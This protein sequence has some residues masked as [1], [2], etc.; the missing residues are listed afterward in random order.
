MGSWPETDPQTPAGE[1]T[2]ELTRDPGRGQEPLD[3]PPPLPPGRHR[4]WV[5]RL[6]VCSIILLPIGLYYYRHHQGR[7]TGEAS[8]LGI[9]SGGVATTVAVARKGNIGVYLEAIGTVTPVYT[10]N[11]TSQVNGVVTAVHY[12]EGQMVKKGDLLVDIDPR[13]YEAFAFMSLRAA[14]SRLRQ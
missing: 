14:P 8:R 2:P 13:P 5:W 9:P 6:L 11:V 12:V 10:V 4:A 3:Q 7:A 1:G